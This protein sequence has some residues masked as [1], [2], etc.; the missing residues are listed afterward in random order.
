MKAIVLTVP[1]DFKRLLPLYHLLGEN[2]PVEEIV[3]IGDCEVGRLL[4]QADLGAQYRHLDE[5][6]LLPLAGVK[7]VI[8]DMFGGKAVT[9]GFAGW[10][11]QQF[12]KLAYASV[13]E[14]AYYL[15]WDG[16]TVPIRR[17]S[18]FTQDKPY[19]GLKNEYHAPYFETLSRLFPGMHKVIE[20]SFIA[21]HMVFAKDLVMQM[22]DEVM[23]AEH[24]QGDNFY[25]RILRAVGTEHLNGNSFSEFETYGTY[26]AFRQPQRY[27]LRRWNSFRYCGS[28]FTPEDITQEEIDWLAKDFQAL[29]FE[30]G[31]TPSPQ[32]DFFRNPKYR[33]RLSARYILEVI[34]ENSTEGYIEKW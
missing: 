21:E 27:E 25:E 22:L 31:D 5:N 14:D 30:K 32:A 1:S 34:Q 24:L 2:L 26:V 3:F 12:L 33:S 11:Y 19:M 13:C 17:L 16:D 10:Y 15:S 29:S 9:R 18:F 28:Y 20:D 6:T 7:A 8:E 4:E 23:Q